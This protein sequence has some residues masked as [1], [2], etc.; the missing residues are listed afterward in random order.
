M[1]V[2]ILWKIISYSLAKHKE[3]D[4]YSELTEMFKAAISIEQQLAFIEKYIT[5]YPEEMASIFI[6]KVGK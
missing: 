3:Q 6:S 1:S 5:D 4:N 2:K